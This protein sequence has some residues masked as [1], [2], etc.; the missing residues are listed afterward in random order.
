VVGSIAQQL[1]ADFLKRFKKEFTRGRFTFVRR[2]T[3]LQAM[4][5][6]GI[7]PAD[8]EQ[9]ILGLTANDYCKGPENDEDGSPGEVWVFGTALD[10]TQIYIKLKLDAS[11]AKCISFHPAGFK[12]K[13]PLDEK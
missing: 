9:I 10:R 2:E 13:F 8:A 12:M 5:F 3:S 11:V 6:L 7:M 1:A 4:A